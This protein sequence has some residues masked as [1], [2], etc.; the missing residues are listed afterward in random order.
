MWLNV[1][2]YSFS[3]YSGGFIWEPKGRNNL[4]L[5]A[6]EPLIINVEINTEFTASKLFKLECGTFTNTFYIQALAKGV[7]TMLIKTASLQ[8][9]LCVYRSFEVCGDFPVLVHQ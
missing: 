3:F 9:N 6:T 5:W 2:N 7:H 8:V 4:M 1:A